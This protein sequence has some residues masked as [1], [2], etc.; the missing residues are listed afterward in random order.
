MKTNKLSRTFASSIFTA[1]LLFAGGALT[2]CDS[3]ITG[4]EFVDVETVDIQA[5]GDKP[6]GGVPT[7]ADHNDWDPDLEDGAN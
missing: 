7:G 4:P 2:G 1:A 5:Q 6:V 3:V